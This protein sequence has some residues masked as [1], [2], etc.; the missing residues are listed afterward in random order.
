M[1]VCVCVGVCGNVQAVG[2]PQG[3]QRVVSSD[4]SELA[5]SVFSFEVALT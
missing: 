1:N 2:K 3:Q 5:E 4:S